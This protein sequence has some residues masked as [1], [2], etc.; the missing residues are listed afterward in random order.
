MNHHVMF[1]LSRAGAIILA[2]LLVVSVAGCEEGGAFTSALD[3]VDDH[4]GE[5]EEQSVQAS[6]YFV[7]NAGYGVRYSVTD[8][9]ANSGQLMT[10][11][12]VNQ[13]DLSRGRGVI[14]FF[15]TQEITNRGPESAL[16]FSPQLS[17]GAYWGFF[18]GMPVRNTANFV[19]LIT[20][21]PDTIIAGTQLAEPGR[22]VL[23]YF[24]EESAVVGG[25][26][27]QDVVL[28]NATVDDALAEE[29]GGTNPEYFAGSG[30][31]RLAPGVGLVELV[32]NRANGQ[33]LRIELGDT[34]QFSPV[35]VSGTVDDGANVLPSVFVGIDA[36]VDV[37]ELL[38]TPQTDA[39]GA[40]QVSLYGPSAHMWIGND[41]NDDGY[42][43]FDD[44]IYHEEFIPDTSNATGITITVGP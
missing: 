2:V 20:V 38:A 24:I 22:P 23:E 3:A 31:A 1:H 43:S 42:L 29:I 25:I 15:P 33:T 18:G 7:L 19:R 14:S 4:R 12:M 5:L 26:T 27:Y 17:G 40:F 36:E 41:D 9:D 8:P 34:D 11:W 16:L 39:S 10:V 28:I 21:V 35:I 37:D 30:F 32:Y 44:G 13:Q 6:D